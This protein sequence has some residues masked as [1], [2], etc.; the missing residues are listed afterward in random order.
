MSR[1]WVCIIE[2]EHDKIP[3]GFDSTPR[4]GAVKAVEK[5]GVEVKNCWSGW[6]C[7]EKRFHEI[8]DVWNR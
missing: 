3:D 4:R 1:Y 2:T 7:D 5:E 6:G 8:M